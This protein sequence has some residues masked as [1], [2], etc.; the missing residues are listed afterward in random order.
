VNTYYPSS[1]LCHRCGFKKGNLKLS[2]RQWDCPKCGTKY[3]R[4]YNTTL[5]LLKEGLTRLKRAVGVD[6]PELMPVE[7]AF[8]PCEAGSSSLQ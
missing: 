2:E 3:D 6:C 5:N 1:K 8:V 7:G 4:D